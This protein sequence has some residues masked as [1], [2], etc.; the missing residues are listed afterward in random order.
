MRAVAL[1]ASELLL[2]AAL[3]GIHLAAG[4]VQPP[5][6]LPSDP[7]GDRTREIGFE[8]GELRLQLGGNIGQVLADLA[9]NGKRVGERRLL[10]Q[11]AALLDQH[12]RRLVYN[13]RC[14]AAADGHDAAVALTHRLRPA[15]AHQLALKRQHEARAD[16]GGQ[17][18][19]RIAM[20]MRKVRDSLGREAA[21]QREHTPH[22]SDLDVALQVTPEE[23]AHN[24]AYPH[25][26]RTSRSESEPCT[27]RSCTSSATSR[28][29]TS[30]IT[31]SRCSMPTRRTLHV[32]LTERPTSPPVRS[33]T[34]Q[35]PS[36]SRI[37]T[38]LPSGTRSEQSP[39]LS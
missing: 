9:A 2:N 17:A 4:V 6:D 30:P 24:L 31:S 18:E 37:S 34:R 28:T 29:R 5:L 11:L 3:R 8:R 32:P 27:A 39:T 1:R 7:L 21:A 23:V 14:R 38:V 20:D 25:V 15:F 26:S 33:L 10:V 36:T 19:H 13:D 35:S 16:I 22:L 12:H